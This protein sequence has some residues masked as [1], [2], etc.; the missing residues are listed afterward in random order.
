M[1]S[2]PLSASE[3]PRR[4]QV[5]KASARL[6]FLRDHLNRC[7]IINY[8][9]LGA[10]GKPRKEKEK[11]FCVLFHDQT[12][13]PLGTNAGRG[14]EGKPLQAQSNINNNIKL[15]GKEMQASAW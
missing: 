3:R 12:S 5:K 1:L 9:D 2:I 13:P 6:A 7:F 10:F 15:K 4:K 14:G 8:G 11:K